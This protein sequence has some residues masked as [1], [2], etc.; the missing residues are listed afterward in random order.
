MQTRIATIALLALA[1]VV[2]AAVLLFRAPA[3]A[4]SVSQ[5]PDATAAAERTS[6][7]VPSPQRVSRRAVSVLLRCIWRRCRLRLLPRPP[8]GPGR[9]LGCFQRQPLSPR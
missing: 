2:G 7:A 3:Y 8:G 9:R 6:T 4:P 1:G 5:L